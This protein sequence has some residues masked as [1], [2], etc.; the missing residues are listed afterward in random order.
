MKKLFI[1]YCLMAPD[2]SRKW[3][4]CWGVSLNRRESDYIRYDSTTHNTISAHACSVPH[5]L[6]KSI[7]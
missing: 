3:V 7:S 4:G 5:D 1:V 2:T 6:A